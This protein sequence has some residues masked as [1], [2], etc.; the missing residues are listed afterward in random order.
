MTSRVCILTDSTAQFT[1]EQFTGHE[2][3]KVIPFQIQLNGKLYPDSRNLKLQDLPNTISY[4]VFPRL[5]SPT[6]EDFQQA[7]LSLEEEYDEIIT[8]LLS[9]NLSPSIYNARTAANSIFGK[10]SLQI[11]DSRSIGVG[12]GLL[13]QA[14][15]EALHN[16]A[17]T[18]EIQLLARNLIPHLY[19]FFCVQ[20]LTYLCRTANLDSA[21]AF[22]GEMLGIIPVIILENGKLIPI[23]KANNPRQM[24]D[25]LYEFVSEFSDL[26]K[27]A[28]IKG[29]F[30][31]NQETRHI[32]ERITGMFPTISY[33]EHTLD[34]ALA[35]MLGP[36]SLG[37]V[38][39][40]N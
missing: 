10:D 24:V 12:L 21:Q 27:I 16:G 28:L 22:V 11:I 35:S 7:Y 31:F 26:Q 13:V 40:E 15:A 29:T 4:S 32:R 3:V 34:I 23:Q 30:P 2:L 1:S 18:F 33:S 17:S 6:P 25:L 20:S 36:S 9:A 39:L 14:I 38:A 5:I 8:V 19:S 37:L